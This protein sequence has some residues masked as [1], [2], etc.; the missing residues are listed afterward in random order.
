MRAPMASSPSSWYARRRMALCDR[1]RA[2]PPPGTTPCLSAALVALTA[3]SMR[4]LFSFRLHLGR[5]ATEDCYSAE[6]LGQALP[7]RTAVIVGPCVVD[8]GLD[9]VDPALDFLVGAG[10]LEDGRF[11]SR[12]HHLSGPAQQGKRCVS[13]SGSPSSVMTLPPVRTAMSSSI[14]LRRPG[15]P[16]ALTA[17]DSKVPRDLV[18]HQHGQ[19]LILDVFCDYR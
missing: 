6:Q 9:L 8:L 10:P 19:G 13:T 17:T 4:C 2:R 7:R 11:V 14:A 12:D 15:K 1:R 18:G 16:G 5:R 3:A